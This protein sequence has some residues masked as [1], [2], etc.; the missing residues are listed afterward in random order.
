MGPWL[1]PVGIVAGLP[2]VCYLL[3]L[4]CGPEGCLDLLPFKAPAM[5]QLGLSDGYS[6]AGLAVFMGWIGYVVLLHL[7]LPGRVVEGV[8]LADGKRLKYKMNGFSIL[9]LT[10]ALVGYLGFYHSLLDLPWVHRNFLQV[11]TGAVGFSFA[12]SL[13]LYASS[14]VKGKLLAA[15]GNTSVGFYNFFIGRELNPR[16]GSLDL[17]EFFELYPGLIGWVVLDLCM[18]A[19]QLQELGHIT[20]SMI[21]VCAFHLIYVVDGLWYEPAI[22]TTMDI[23]ADGFGFMLVF[24]DIAWVPFTYCLQARYLADNPRDI[25]PV[26]IMAILLLKV[27]GYWIFRGANG[28]KNMFRQDPTHPSVS[29][30][31]TMPTERGTK[32]IISGWWGIVRHINYTGDWLMGLAWCLPC[33]YQHIIPYFY[34]IYFGVLLIHREMRDEHACR[35]KYGKDWGKYCSIV[36]YRLVPFVY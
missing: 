8:Q 24:G 10:L 35:E 30:L 27:L 9:V 14:F 4:F 19:S 15:G 33:G 23:T 36:K 16:I 6:H 25:P 22:L 5:G 34:A 11:L 20:N 32:L 26:E 2:C 12:L 18:A 31:K 3:V 13:Y 17:K 29:H 1:G 28:Q 7:L 21:L